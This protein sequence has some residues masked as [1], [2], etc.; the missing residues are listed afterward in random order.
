MQCVYNHI[1]LIPC[2]HYVLQLGWVVGKIVWVQEVQQRVPLQPGQWDSFHLGFTFGASASCYFGGCVQI[3]LLPSRSNTFLESLWKSSEAVEEVLG[4]RRSKV[5]N[6]S[7][8][9][10]IKF[11]LLMKRLIFAHF[12]FPLTKGVQSFRVLEFLFRES[13]SYSWKVINLFGGKKGSILALFCQSMFLIRCIQPFAT[14]QDGE[15]CKVGSDNGFTGSPAHNG[16]VWEGGVGGRRW[17]VGWLKRSPLSRHGCSFSSIMPGQ[18]ISR[19]ARQ[20]VATWIVFGRAGLRYQVL[21][22]GC[23]CHRRN[24]SAAVFAAFKKCYR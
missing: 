18:E 2:R 19:E 4:I 9:C 5:V 10:F 22:L 11:M 3:Y 16:Q 14:Q 1:I 13:I 24:W 21:F 7:K 17:F 12:E 8:N 6:T 20:K 23:P 15:K